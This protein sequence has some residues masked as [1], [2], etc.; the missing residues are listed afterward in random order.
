MPGP[1]YILIDTLKP[2]G[3]AGKQ[4]RSHRSKSAVSMLLRSITCGLRVILFP[5]ASEVMPGKGTVQAVLK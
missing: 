5:V 3:G 2:H 4:W 1:V